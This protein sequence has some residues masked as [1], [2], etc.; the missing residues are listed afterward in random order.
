MDEIQQL[1]QS[2]RRRVEREI[3]VY[4]EL[5]DS[6]PAWK[7]AELRKCFGKSRFGVEAW[8]VASCSYLNGARPIDWIFEDFPTVIDAA[9]LQSAP[10]GHG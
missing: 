1:E 10:I 4:R 3:T 9:R 7:V 2:M 8:L 5:L 6:I